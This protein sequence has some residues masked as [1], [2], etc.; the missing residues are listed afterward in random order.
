MTISN[1]I[2]KK[3]TALT[4]FAVTGLMVW[5]IRESRYYS[6]LSESM[7]IPEHAEAV[8]I[9]HLLQSMIL[10]LALFYVLCLLVKQNRAADKVRHS[11]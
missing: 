7:D 4:A 9:G 3:I 8:G 10:G 1:I 6:D 2:P 11:A 5:K